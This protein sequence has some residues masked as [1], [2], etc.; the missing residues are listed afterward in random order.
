[1]I[2]FYTRQMAHRECRRFVN[3]AKQRVFGGENM[4][5]ALHP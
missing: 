4:W 1:M 2:Q 5:H 3:S